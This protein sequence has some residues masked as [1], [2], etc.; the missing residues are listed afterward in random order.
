MEC[1]DFVPIILFWGVLA[2]AFTRR[3]LVK[4]RQLG[5]GISPVR[6]TIRDYVFALSAI[7]FSLFFVQVIRNLLDG[8]NFGVLEIFA[9]TIVM[10]LFLI[11]SFFALKKFGDSKFKISE[12]EDSPVKCAKFGVAVVLLMIPLMFLTSSL[13]MLALGLMT[14]GEVQKQEVLETIS[15]SSGFWDFAVSGISVIVTAPI[16]EELIFRCFLYRGLKGLFERETLFGFSKIFLGDSVSLRAKFFAVVVSSAIFAYIHFTI[17]AFVPIFF[18]GIIFALAYERTKSIWT[19]IAM[20][21]VF[22]AVN[23]ALIGIVGGME[24]FIH[25]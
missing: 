24:G 15:E 17:S 2:L 5:D 22:N 18:L 12:T 7:C 19:P 25:A 14:G 20:H 1:S 16:C 23:F 21:A 3:G 6:F 4:L 13:A 8:E 11:I 9:M 10:H